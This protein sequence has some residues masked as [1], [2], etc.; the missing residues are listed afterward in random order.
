MFAVFKRARKATLAAAAALSALTLAA[1]DPAT[2]GSGPTINTSKPV[3]VALLVPRGSAQQG[4]SVLAKSLENA[5]RLAIADLDGV[6]IDLRVYDTAGTPEVASS[7]AQQALNDGARIILGPVYAEAANAA[8]IAARQR[9]VN[10]LAF[11]NNTAIAGGN[12]F[13]LG[14]TFDNTAR[15]LTKFAARNGKRNILIVGGNDAAGVAGR[16]A[17]QQAAAES[18]ATITR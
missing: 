6:Q 11:S 7:A 15:R 10:V 14:P 9:G 4:D 18:G 16:T 13:I 8:G 17:I 2:I 1:C 5:A 12:V 3:P